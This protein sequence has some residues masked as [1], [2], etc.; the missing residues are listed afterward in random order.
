M[1]IHASMPEKSAPEADRCAPFLYIREKNR[2]AHLAQN[3]CQ[4]TRKTGSAVRTKIEVKVRQRLS[5]DQF[6]CSHLASFQRNEAN[7]RR[8]MLR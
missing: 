3:H 2:G 7:M 6:I 5:I 8:T 4:S 1:G